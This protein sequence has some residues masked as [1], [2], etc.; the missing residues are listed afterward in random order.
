VVIPKPGKP[1]YSKVRAYRVIS[2]LDF[3]SK[4]LERTAAH[5]IADHLERKR[6]LHDGRFGCWKRWSCVDAVVVLMNRTQQVWKRKM[7]AGGLFMDVKSDFN[8]VSRVH[9]GKRM[10]TLGIEPD[11]TRW[12]A[13]FMSDRQVKLVL[14]D[15]TGGASP[16]DTGIPQGSPAAPIL[17]VT[18]PSAIFDKAE[19]VVPGV[20]GLSVV[21]DI[22]WWAAG[23]DDEVVAAMLSAAA[24]VAL[25]WAA[26]NGVTFDHSKT[27]AALFQ[28]KKRTT[29]ATVTVGTNS[30][31][32]NREATR[33]LGV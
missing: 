2:L 17:F 25:E 1:D 20:Y 13:S 10:E 23:T 22:G 5:L 29:T 18:Y 8:N 12:T 26:G 4:L 6:G 3:V 14:D 11:L 28:R 24:A 16:V 7:V 15:I 32:F 27:E 9:L 33:W 31:P 19:E 21:D 30:I